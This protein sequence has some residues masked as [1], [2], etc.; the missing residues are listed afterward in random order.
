MESGRKSARKVQCMLKHE[1]I[2]K[3]DFTFGL[4]RKFTVIKKKK[5]RKKKKNGY[6]LILK[7]GTYVM[8]YWKTCT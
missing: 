5:E 7:K 6:D 8:R 4:S 2:P 1:E 3:I